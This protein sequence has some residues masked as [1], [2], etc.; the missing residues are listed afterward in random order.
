MKLCDAMDEHSNFRFSVKIENKSE[1]VLFNKAMRAIYVSRSDIDFLGRDA[2]RLE[3][4]RKKQDTGLNLK[5]IW[6]IKID[7]DIEITIFKK[8]GNPTRR[9]TY[10][11]TPCEYKDDIPL[12]KYTKE[13]KLSMHCVLIDNELIVTI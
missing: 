1:C 6:N 3:F 7:Y 9:Y 2:Q 5:Y 8:D 10:K 13:E 4:Y 12:N 11:G